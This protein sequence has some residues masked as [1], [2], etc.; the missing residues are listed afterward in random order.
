VTQSILGVE[1]LNKY[2]L[3]CGSSVQSALLCFTFQRLILI[4]S[5]IYPFPFMFCDKKSVAVPPFH[6]AQH[7]ELTYFGHNT[8]YKS[9]HCVDHLPTIDT[10]MLYE[11]CFIC[12]LNLTSFMIQYDDT[13]SGIHFLAGSK[14]SLSRVNTRERMASA[15]SSASINIGSLSSSLHRVGSVPSVLRRLFSRDASNANTAATQTST[16]DG[17]G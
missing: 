11:V 3:F 15:G 10:L 6:R 7:K 17:G 13:Q 14:R 8:I 16:I 12:V 4:L 5:L 1:L 9:L 2:C